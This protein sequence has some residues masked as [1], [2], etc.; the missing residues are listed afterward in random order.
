M[1]TNLRIFNSPQFGMIR[2]DGTADNP[3]FCAS[4]ICFAISS[5]S[6]SEK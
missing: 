4:D 2:T 1:K 5:S 3:L 6:L